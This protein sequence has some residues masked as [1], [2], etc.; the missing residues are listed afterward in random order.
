MGPVISTGVF[1]SSAAYHIIA[2][3]LLFHEFPGTLLIESSHFVGGWPLPFLGITLLLALTTSYYPSFSLRGPSIRLLVYITS[4]TSLTL[5]FSLMS[6]F[7]MWSLRLML[8]RLFELLI[9]IFII[10]YTF[11]AVFF[12]SP[13]VLLIL[14]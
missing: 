3:S 9:M 4:T 10:F 2:I 6:L 1:H 14:A 7:L 12:R 8:G 5:V 11:Y 13:E